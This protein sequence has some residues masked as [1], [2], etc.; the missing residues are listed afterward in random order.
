MTDISRRDMLRAS[1]L[2]AAGAAADAVLHPRLE[3]AAPSYVMHV[4]PPRLRFGVI[5][6]NHGHIYGQCEA[7]IRGGGEL[8]A[9]FAKE[10]DLA[11]EFARRYPKARQVTDERAI[12][13]DPGIQLVVSAI[14]PDQRA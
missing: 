7:V 13:E 3:A 4:G 1:A 10:P 8:A 9:F 5:G 12:L 6:M 14:I 2:A 11:A